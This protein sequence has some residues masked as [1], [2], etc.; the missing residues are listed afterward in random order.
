[1]TGISKAYLRGALL[2]IAG[3]NT[4]NEEDKKEHVV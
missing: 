3:R 2:R 1:M 4:E